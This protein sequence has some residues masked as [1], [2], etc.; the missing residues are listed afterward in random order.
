MK[1]YCICILLIYSLNVSAQEFI[2]DYISYKTSFKD[3][4]NDEKNFVEET[5]F[6]IAVFINENK[7]DGDI[8]IQDPIIPKK[9]LAYRIVSFKEEIKQNNITLEIY[10]A[11]AEHL[12]A[13][14]TVTITFYIDEQKNLNLM[15]SDEKS[16]QIFFDLVSQ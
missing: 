13:K 14:P 5:N 6:N 4:V 16:S 12:D 9:L 8:I 7:D 10:E 3:E 11:T 15:I 1:T 2:G